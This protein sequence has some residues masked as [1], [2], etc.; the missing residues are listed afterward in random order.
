[1][2]KKA[3]NA[4][5]SAFVAGAIGLMTLTPSYAAINAADLTAI[6]TE[7]TTDVGTVTTW[8]F[9]LLAIILGAMIGFALVKK[10]GRSAAG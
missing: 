1:M 7:V 9:G 2:L 4:V 3:Y 6:T 10:F 5:K 8:A